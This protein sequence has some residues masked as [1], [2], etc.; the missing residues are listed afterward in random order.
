MTEGGK[1]RL[2]LYREHPEKFL[3]DIIDDSP[4]WPKQIE[5]IESVRD[6]RNTYVKSC[7]G[8]GKTYTAKDVALWF[9]YCHVP[10]IVI[11][12]APS[13]PQVE[14][15]LWAEIN[16]AHES[17]K[18]PLGG[19]CLK[20]A[21]NIKPKWY[22]V[23]ISPKIES[24]DDGSRMTGFHSPHMLVIFDE[25]PAV[26]SKLWEIKETLM[27]SENVRF[28]AIGNPVLDSGHFF[29]GFRDDRVNSINMS[30][31]DS[32]NFVANKVTSKE[33]LVA[34]SKMK[35]EDRDK[36]LNEMKNPYPSL[37]NVAWAVDRLL[38]WGMDSPIFQARVMSEFPSAA[39]QSI[40][41]YS[42]LERCKGIEPLTWSTKYKTEVP[43]KHH[44]C[45]GVDVARFGTDN[46]CFL[47]YEN[48]KQIY[49]DSW[50][51]QNIVKTANRIKHLIV[52][53]K[54]RTIVI[55]DTGLGGGVTDLVTEF[56]GEE[57]LK[58]LVIAVNF[59]A[60][61]TN[62]IYDG[63][64]TQMY[65]NARDMIKEQSISMTDEGSLFKELSSRNYKYTGKGL[66]K[67]EGKE[68]YKKRTGFPSPDEADAFI[69]C[70]WGINQE[71]RD[72]SSTGERG[73]VLTD[74]NSLPTESLPGGWE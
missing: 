69:L 19:A 34:I 60:A 58:V 62:P 11:T 70:Q 46:T 50:N 23:G 48:G 59:A 53:E 61:S 12:T 63:I 47:G 42:S 73:A 22:A 35:R 45:L 44:K 33:K 36:L 29:E 8:V 67:V 4:R 3:N 66:I 9:L 32:P 27:T 65:Y 28:L 71:E 54:Y 41:S 2:K 72:I 13:W 6:N 74:L 14:K 43:V 15:L 39:Q 52:K 20:T 55:D 68:D 10:S 57:K 37:T 31:F 1:D 49:K 30:I 64:V 51:G 21:L 40:I 25:A 17:A 38:A 7:H 24:S 18:V 56:V 26:N 16:N 5:I